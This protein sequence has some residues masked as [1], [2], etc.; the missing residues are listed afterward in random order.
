[1]VG[2]TANQVDR[3]VED[4]T[5]KSGRMTSWSAAGSKSENSMQYAVRVISEHY[6]NLTVAQIEQRLRYSTFVSLSKRY[7]YFEVPKAGCTSL[8]YMILSLEKLPKP[9]PFVGPHRE[10]RREMFIHERPQIRLPSLLDVADNMQREVLS[11]TEFLRFTCVRNP[12]TRLQSAWNDKIRLCAP[13]YG[14]IYARA[15]RELPSGRR[16]DSIIS[17]AEFV[18]MLSPKGIEICDPHWRLQSAHV[19]LRAINYSKIGQLESLGS[20]MDAISLHV[21]EDAMSPGAMNETASSASSQYDETLARRV[22]NIFAEDFENFGYSGEEWPRQRAQDNRISEAKFLDEVIERNIVINELYEQRD[23]MREMTRVK[24]RPFISR[25]ANASFD[26]LFEQHI[27]RTDG[28]LGKSEAELLYGLAKGL[29]ANN[30]VVE[31]GAY[32]GRSTVALAFGSIAGRQA[33]VYSIDPHEEFVGPLGGRFGSIDRGHFMQKMVELGLFHIVRLVNLSSDAIAGRW[34]QPIGL[35]WVDG[36]HSY[37]GVSRDFNA[38]K[39]KLSDDADLVFDDAVEPNSG[40]GKLVREI[41]AT[42]TFTVVGS[43]G[44]SVHL[45]KSA[46]Q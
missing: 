46:A 37:D 28:W 31:V 34:S 10:V 39:D 19:F 45:K 20:L 26:D 1:V 18:G 41:T 5:T 36:D 13:R 40:P 30:C 21:G 42:D 44:K 32:R 35:L 7:M 11:S 2:E 33:P 15:M 24:N 4:G 38:W 25:Y 6:P 12:Y 29:S 14:A 16:P 17:F 3:L 23:A 22:R 27:K 43:V 8:K 9:T